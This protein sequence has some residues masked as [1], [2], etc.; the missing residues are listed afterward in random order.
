MI[1]GSQPNT[2]Q[3]ENRRKYFDILKKQVQ[4]LENTYYKSNKYET[5]A[6]NV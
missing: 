3:G 6:F 4:I 2:E 5:K 1:N